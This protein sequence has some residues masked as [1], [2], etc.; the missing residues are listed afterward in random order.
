MCHLILL[1]VCFLFNELAVIEDT[2]SKYNEDAE[3]YKE[4]KEKY[5]DTTCRNVD[6]L[7]QS[8]HDQ[9]VSEEYEFVPQT[10]VQ[11]QI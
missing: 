1:L 2:E 7:L 3:I 11:H 6:K 5:H 8:P 10:A 9:I 4:L